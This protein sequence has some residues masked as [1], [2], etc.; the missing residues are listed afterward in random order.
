MDCLETD[1]P[2]FVDDSHMSIFLVPKFY[3][4]GILT[5]EEHVSRLTQ[6]WWS[7]ECGVRLLITSVILLSD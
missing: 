3:M 6:Q 1:N 2:A 5:S 7:A 4:G